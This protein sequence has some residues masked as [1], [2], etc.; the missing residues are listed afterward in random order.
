MSP[1]LIKNT[2]IRSQVIYE[3]KVVDD[4]KRIVGEAYMIQSSMF[5]VGRYLD[6]HAFLEPSTLS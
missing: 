2:L 5:Q 3:T 6:V 1:L 4:F